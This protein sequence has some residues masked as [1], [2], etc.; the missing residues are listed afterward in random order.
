VEIFEVHPRFS[1]STSIRA[2]VGFN[3]PDLLIRN[4]IHGEPIGRQTYLTDVAAIRAFANE[5]VPAAELEAIPRVQP[6]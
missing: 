6:D 2:Q 5:I 3:E 1:G 4:Y